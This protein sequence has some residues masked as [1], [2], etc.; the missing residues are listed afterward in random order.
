MGYLP[1]WELPPTHSEKNEENSCFFYLFIL[2]LPPPHHRQ[3]NSLKKKKFY[4]LLFP[5][6]NVIPIHPF[7]RGM[8]TDESDQAFP[9]LPPHP[10]FHPPKKM[11]DKVQSYI[12]LALSLLAWG[13]VVAILADVRSWLLFSTT[14]V[15]GACGV[16]RCNVVVDGKAISSLAKD[17][18]GARA[19]CAKAAQGFGAAAVSMITAHLAVDVCVA[20][21]EDLVPH[22]TL[23]HA[24][25]ARGVTGLLLLVFWVILFIT[26]FADFGT[27]EVCL[28]DGASS[29]SKVPGVVAGFGIYLA[30]GLVLVESANFFFFVSW[31][32]SPGAARQQ[33]VHHHE[34][35]LRRGSP[36]ASPSQSPTN[37]SMRVI[38]HPKEHVYDT[39]EDG[40]GLMSSAYS[41]RTEPQ[42][43]ASLKKSRAIPVIHVNEKGQILADDEEDVLAASLLEKSRKGLSVSINEPGREEVAEEEEDKD[44]S[45]RLETARLIE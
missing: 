27:D 11:K 21:R 37:Q 3:H 41:A 19:K 39:Y 13:V 30:G 15:D 1:P 14:G 4:S 42:K 38:V 35:P 5:P 31:K 34:V 7:K 28:M 16:F 29:L 20:F 26:Y 32:V 43:G 23:H 40:P 6:L 44:E 33:Q 10:I 8:K 36:S 2:I 18:C 12:L 25:Y 22:A 9:G 45:V 24:K 17:P